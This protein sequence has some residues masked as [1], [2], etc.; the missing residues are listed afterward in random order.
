VLAGSDQR[1]EGA[2]GRR[3]E[4]RDDAPELR[5]Q[6]VPGRT[7]IGEG[8]Q[9]IG[10]LQEGIDGDRLFVGPSAVDSRLADPRARRSR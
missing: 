9:G 2:P 4:Q 3:T 6:V 5:A 8:D 7:G 1:R 10:V